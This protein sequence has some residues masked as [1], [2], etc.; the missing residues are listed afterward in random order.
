MVAK[1]SKTSHLTFR[2]ICP[3]CKNKHVEAENTACIDC[4]LSLPRTDSHLNPHNSVEKQIDGRFPFERIVTFS[5]FNKGGTLQPIIH[6]LKYKNNPHIGISIGE[7]FGLQLLQSPFITTIDF[8]V[9]IPLHKRKIKKRGYNQSLLIAQ[10]ISR[11]TGIPISDDNLTREIDNPSQTRLSKTQRWQNVEGIFKLNNP[12][13]FAGK[14][15]LL[16]DDIITTGST[17]EACAHTL[18]SAPNI[19]ISVATIGEAIQN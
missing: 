15:I 14:H 4:L 2:C 6:E 3:V 1:P 7:A 16:L 17:I 13:Q 5:K 11:T 18:L 9:P 10:G 8:I 19:K 12:P